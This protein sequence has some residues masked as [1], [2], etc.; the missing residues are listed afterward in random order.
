MEGTLEERFWAKVDVR[1]PED[2]WEWLAGKTHNGYGMIGKGGRHNGMLRAHRVSWE[3]ANGPIP[4]G[5][6][7][8][9]H[10]D[11]PG[12]VNPL[13]LWIG[14]NADNQQDMAQKGRA[15][16]NKGE[17][18]GKAKLTA[19]DV[20][21]IRQMLSRDISHRVIA[22]VYGVKRSTISDINIGRCWDW[23]EEAS[24]DSV[25]AQPVGQ[26]ALEV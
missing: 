10:C 18:N 8:L 11:N 6:C 19:Q 22:K 14:T 5:L 7:V 20:H 9:H 1:G 16:S 15:A 3:L 25:K 13:H 26:L 12:C 4:D 2:C 23:L 17:S 24:R 21:E